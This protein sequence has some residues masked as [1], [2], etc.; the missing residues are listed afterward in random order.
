M[1]ATPDLSRT[2][3]YPSSDGKK[4]TKYVVGKDGKFEDVVQIS[5][6]EYNVWK[7]ARD[8]ERASKKDSAPSQSK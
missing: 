4:A 6:A 3:C 2:M 7:A 5:D 8:A 1:Q